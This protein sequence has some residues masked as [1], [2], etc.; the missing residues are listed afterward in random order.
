MIAIRDRDKQ[1]GITITQ[2]AT[3]DRALLNGID[4]AD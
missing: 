4:L 2:K 3:R 1:G